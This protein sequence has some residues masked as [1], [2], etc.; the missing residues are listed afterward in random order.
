M[1]FTSTGDGDKEVV[2]LLPHISYTRNRC[3][4][5]I[6]KMT[7]VPKDL[8][9]GTIGG[10]TQLIVG[11]PFDTINVKL[12]SQS[13]DSWAPLKVSDLLGKHPHLMKDGFLAGDMDKNDRDGEAGARDMSTSTI[14]FKS[15]PSCR[16]NLATSMRWNC[17]I[18]KFDAQGLSALNHCLYKILPF[19]QLH[20]FLKRVAG[21]TMARKGFAAFIEVEGREV[22]STSISTLI[23]YKETDKVDLSL[24]LQYGYDSYQ[25]VLA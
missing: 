14:T 5:S 13:A 10:A 16:S 24:H 21:A 8:T 20:R 19:V 3:Q 22:H 9:V 2:V 7:E 15:A 11:H 17:P 25:H 1:K 12:Q 6:I 18:M 4:S 23:K